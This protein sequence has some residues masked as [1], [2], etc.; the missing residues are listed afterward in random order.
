MQADNLGK[1]RHETPL[2]QQLTALRRL[3][4][5]AEE[6]RWRCALVGPEL[7][8]GPPESGRPASPV[9]LDDVYSERP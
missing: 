5:L 9:V 6:V 3:S 1:L 4:E 2:L 7:T 8:S